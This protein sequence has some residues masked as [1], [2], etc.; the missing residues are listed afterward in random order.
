MERWCFESFSSPHWLV[1]YLY[2]QSIRSFQGGGRGF[3][4]VRSRKAEDERERKKTIDLVDNKVGFPG[5][6]LEDVPYQVRFKRGKNINQTRHEQKHKSDFQQP[7][8]LF[9]PF[10]SFI[11]TI[12]YMYVKDTTIRK[13]VFREEAAPALKIVYF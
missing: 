6:H 11:N 13:R 1:Q 9:S 7:A 12:R 4:L 5:F 10:F 8:I 2:D 3:V